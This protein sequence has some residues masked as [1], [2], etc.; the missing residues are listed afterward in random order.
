MGRPSLKEQRRHE[1]LDAFVRCVAR[2]G[3][4]GAT[5]ERLAEESG[6][7]RPLIRHHLG[8]RE[9][10]IQGLVNHVVDKFDTQVTQ[11]HEYLDGKSRLPTLLALLF[12]SDSVTDS[13]L[14]LAFAALTAWAEQ[15][16]LARK[17][18]LDSVVRFEQFLF[19]ELKESYPA[20]TKQQLSAVSQA[21]LALCFNLDALS[22][23]SP[24]HPWRVS[25]RD[26]A[27]MLIRG[28][29]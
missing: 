26:A 24:P 17:T 11:M 2:H 27:D 1:I 14:V 13:D 29:E 28:L 12:S 15:D 21:L 4:Y 22:P 6:L 18:L 19:N 3:L 10:M 20:S 7:K 25:A 8:N 16:E 23:L 9:E 5:L